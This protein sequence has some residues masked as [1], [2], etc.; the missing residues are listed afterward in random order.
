MDDG[1]E[2][3]PGREDGTQRLKYTGTP[4]R[5]IDI[6]WY[7]LH[8]GEDEHTKDTQDYP[9][10][11]DCTAANTDGWMRC[12]PLFHRHRGRSSRSMGSGICEVLGTKSGRLRRHVRLPHFLFATNICVNDAVLTDVCDPPQPVLRSCTLSIVWQ[13][14]PLV[15]QQWPSLMCFWLTRHN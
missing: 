7:N 13:V 11:H 3:I 6:N 9:A 5:E 15:P 10:N 1:T 8:L 4:S 14:P 2:Y 12:R